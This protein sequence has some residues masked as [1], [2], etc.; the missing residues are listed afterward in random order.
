MTTNQK[1]D[2]EIAMRCSQTRKHFHLLLKRQGQDA[3]A[4]GAV[5]M[6]TSLF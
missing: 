1:P 5:K 6:K 2:A 4:I 3:V